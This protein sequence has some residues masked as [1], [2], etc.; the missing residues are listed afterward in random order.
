MKIIHKKNCISLVYL[1]KDLQFVN[2]ENALR[3][4]RGFSS[5]DESVSFF[6]TFVKVLS[7]LTFPQERYGSYT[8][9]R[10]IRKHIYFL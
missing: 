3:K 9:S 10:E 5:D 1:H 8:G 4:L 7:I 6:C 2:L